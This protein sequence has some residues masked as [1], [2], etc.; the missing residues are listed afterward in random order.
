MTGVRSKTVTVSVADN[1]ILVADAIQYIDLA[2]SGG[3]A[4]DGTTAQVHFWFYDNDKPYPEVA[5][6]SS[7]TL[8]EGGDSETFSVQ[9]NNPPNGD[10]A[11]TLTQ[12]AT[13]PVALTWV[14]SGPLDFT[15]DDWNVPQTVTVSVADNTVLVADAFQRINMT[16]SGG[17]ADVRPVSVDFYVID[18]DKPDLEVSQ[19]SP[20]IVEGGSKEKFS[21]NLTKPPSAD[22]TVTLSLDT[23]NSVALTLDPLGPL[24]FTT[25]NWSDA[26]DV[27]VSVPNNATVEP[28]A[29]QRINLAAS[30]GG[31]DGKTARVGF[32]F[33]DGDDLSLQVSQSGETLIEGGSSE[34]VF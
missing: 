17:G 7:R 2:A 15:I 10:V 29:F 14:P 11:V 1:S 5:S 27:E 19:S 33:Y 20:N 25:G 3:G 21:V 4:K 30:G 13:D 31:A 26:K 18:D 9:L 8:N 28:T 24:T 6:Q 32:W 22:V 16:A 23:G 12:R 34:D